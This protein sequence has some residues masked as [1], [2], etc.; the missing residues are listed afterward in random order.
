MHFSKT[1]FLRDILA[2]TSQRCTGASASLHTT[3][4]VLAKTQSKPKGRP[5]KPP[6]QKRPGAGKLV[7]S[8]RE[9]SPSGRFELA[10]KSSSSRFKYAPPDLD[11]KPPPEDPWR[12]L[13]RP[14]YQTLERE[15]APHEGKI[16]TE[17]LRSAPPPRNNSRFDR[18]R[19]NR[20][21]NRPNWSDRPSDRTTWKDRH[22][23][24]RLQPKESTRDKIPT[25]TFE[26][27][28]SKDLKSSRLLEEDFDMEES[29]APVT[30]LPDKFSSPPLLY[31][32]LQS[33][34]EVLGPTATPSPIQALSLKHLL[35]PPAQQTG[36]K[37]E[38]SFDPAKYK[39]NQYLL[40]SETGSGKS[41]AYL[42]PMLQ[43]LKLTENS[44]AP[45]PDSLTPEGPLGL[46]PRGLILAPTH[47]LSRQ[48]STFAKQLLHNIKL[49]VQCVSQANTSSSS[50][51]TSGTASQLKRAL[52]EKE[53]DMEEATGEITIE[54]RSHPV[55]ILVG[56]PSRILEM[57]RGLGWDRK[58]KI[59]EDWDDARKLRAQNW[60]PGPPT[61]SLRDVE[62]V[63][64]DEADVLFHDEFQQTTRS[65]LADIAQAR[66]YTHPSFATLKSAI[67]STLDISSK[68]SPVNYPFHL[69]FTSA[70]I[71]ISLGAYMTQNHPKLMRLAS[72]KLHQLPSSLHVE[73]CPYT[74]GNKNVDV[75]KKLK[76]LWSKERN[77]K[78]KSK[79][80][81]FCN[82][83]TKVDELCQDLTERGVHCL[84]LSGSSTTRG[85]GS[86]RHLEGFLKGK[87]GEQY[88]LDPRV[89]ITT[90]LLSRGLDFSPTIKYVFILDEPRNM[91]D[92]LHRAGRSGRAGNEGHVIIFTKLS[93]RGSDS[94]KEMKK[95]VDALT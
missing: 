79:V 4:C 16:P 23:A 84:A 11:D 26:S 13:N 49:R 47:E 32:L 69:L 76:A 88:P 46:R 43:Y 12:K 14:S 30:D 8:L 81:I 36:H 73:Y 85:H 37:S 38:G 39:W 59:E 86:N 41:M 50:R 63:V 21:S 53:L 61:L 62:W 48:L 64:V 92:F 3:G 82:K 35:A 75:D 25:R 54:R 67:P 72:P 78:I 45:L 93:G 58:D 60:V 6:P 57:T 29:T 19:D 17:E 94:A 22:A 2:L 74:G 65:L 70:T 56:T 31:G 20:Q 42:L 71:P 80:L 9:V 5:A 90:S 87:E 34:H 55:D 1:I 18:E 68:I 89:L 24:Q 33:V 40:A 77:A 44:P 91:I 27:K 66:G 95:K 28:T 51:G 52:K 15:S 10:G 7:K 83:A